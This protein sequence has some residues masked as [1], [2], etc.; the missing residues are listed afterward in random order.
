MTRHRLISFG[1]SGFLAGALAAGA[2]VAGLA[3]ASAATFLF[4]RPPFEGSTAPG[5]PGRQVVGGEI[6]I[7]VFDFANDVMAFSIPAHGLDRPLAF[8]SAEAADIPASGRN[9]I[10]LRTLDVDGDPTNGITLNAGQ[11]ANLIAAA[12]TGPGP[13]FFI[14][15]N[16]GLD[17]PRLVFSPDLSVNTSD[18]KILARFTGMTGDAGRAAFLNLGAGNF[19]AVPEPA[20]WA[21]LVAGF[22]LVGG[23]A[24]RRAAAVGH[25][26]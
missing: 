9:V 13:G 19:A 21:M 2:L 6:S 25:A 24:R 18:L 1:L 22:G 15:F 3:P 11:A 17:L 10:V 16:S 23:L 20:T 26:I 12:I 5:T 14:Y 7:P 8:L 4:D